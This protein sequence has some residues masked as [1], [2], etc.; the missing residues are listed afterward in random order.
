M[1]RHE[2]IIQLADHVKNKLK[3]HQ[4][5]PAASPFINSSDEFIEINSTDD[6]NGKA[7]NVLSY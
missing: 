3:Q 6:E 2:S 7:E 1:Q 5:L 4:Q